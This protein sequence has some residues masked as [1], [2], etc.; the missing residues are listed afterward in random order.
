MPIGANV[1]GVG[2][3]IVGKN[4]VATVVM[5]EKLRVQFGVNENNQ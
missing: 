4:E 5:V 2:V 1:V 3:A